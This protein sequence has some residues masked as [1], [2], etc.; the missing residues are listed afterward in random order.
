MAPMSDPRRMGAVPVTQAAGGRGCLPPVALRPAG[1][2]PRAGGGRRRPGRDRAGQLALLRPRPQRRAVEGLPLPGAHHGAARGGGS[3]HRPRPRSLG[4]WSPVDAHR[5]DGRPGAGVLRDDRRPPGAPAVPGGVRG[6]GHGQGLRRL[7]QRHRA[8][9][10]AQRRRAGGGQLE[11]PAPVGPGGP[12]RRASRPARLPHRRV[13]GRARRGGGRLPRGRPR[14]APDPDD[15]GGRVAGH[16][17]GV[18]RAAR[19]RHPPGGVGDGARPRHRRLPHVPG[20]FDLRDEPTWQIGAVLLLSGA[21]ALLGSA[22][23]PAIRSR[24]PRSAC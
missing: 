10:R 15:P 8:H 16:R 19:R 21:G 17:G 1:A 24:S 4:R 6:A 11:A 14:G 23:A 20:A 7:A 5:R 18:G 13:R 12:A 9:R 3:V 2:H 22:L